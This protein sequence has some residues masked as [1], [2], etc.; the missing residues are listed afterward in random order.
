MVLEQG[1]KKCWLGVLGKES[2]NVYQVVCNS[3]TFAMRATW[4]VHSLFV[5]LGFVA[6]AKVQSKG[7]QMQ[8]E[9]LCSSYSI[10]FLRACDLPAKS[11]NSHCSLHLAVVF[12]DP[13][14]PIAVH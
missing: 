6:K 9:L 7:C 1:L 3:K 13:S 5:T 2:V 11:C 10:D 4:L 8:D 14:V 12:K